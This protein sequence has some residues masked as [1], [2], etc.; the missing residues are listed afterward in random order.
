[1]M[2]T[3]IVQCPAHHF[4]VL[5]LHVDQCWPASA[6][7]ALALSSVVGGFASR[8]TRITLTGLRSPSLDRWSQNGAVVL[9]ILG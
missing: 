1:M 3:F 5:M 4:P 7:D 2:H 8:A 9:E 6:A